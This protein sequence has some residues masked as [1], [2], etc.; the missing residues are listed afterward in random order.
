MRTVIYYPPSEGET[1]EECGE[2]L[3]MESLKGVFENLFEKVN[4]PTEKENR[5]K[6]K[7]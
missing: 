1:P 5:E 2:R 4:K 3:A 7:G 6:E